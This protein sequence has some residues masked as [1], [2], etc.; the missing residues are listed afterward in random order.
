[1]YVLLPTQNSSSDAYDYAASVRWQEDLW[2]P[3][4]LLY[5]VTG[6]GLY[7]LLQNL[8]FKVAPLPLLQ[9]LNGVLAAGSLVVLWRVLAQ[10]QPSVKVQAGLVL[11]AGAS[12]GTMRYATENETYV[13]P[14]FFSGLGSLYWL[15]YHHKGQASDLVWSSFWAAF[16]CL[17]HQVHFFWWLGLFFS[18]VFFSTHK[19]RLVLV[20]FGLP[21]LVVPLGYAVALL[22]QEI[23]FTQALTFVFKGFYQGQVDTQITYKNFLLTGISFG[24][25]F[26]EVHGRIP[27]LLKHHWVYI[28][29]G[30]T[31]LV[32]GA[33]FLKRIKIGRNWENLRHRPVFKTHGGIMG[34]QL[35][36]AW[37]AVGNA[38]FMVM[39]PWLMAVLLACGTYHR[40]RALFLAG[41]GLLVWNLSFGLV[42]LHLYSFTNF[43]CLS[44]VV[45]QQPKATFFLQDEN[46]FDTFFFYHTGH[47]PA[48]TYETEAAPEVLTQAL[49]VARAQGQPVLTDFNQEPAVLSRK[50]FVARPFAAS[51]FKNYRLTPIASCPTFYGAGP[52]YLVS[53]LTP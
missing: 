36:F 45:L 33:L 20:W 35:L 44:Q 25:T 6:L 27:F 40:S 21:A 46:G 19:K 14:L 17:Y 52:L 41:S 13:L 12:F 4:H 51:F 37:F 50:W 15:R 31:T 28:M 42:P 47:Y 30:M 3:H 11:L 26:L 43:P 9:F 29:F 18:S 34:L 49:A 48:H 5:N 53:D 39:V 7:T 38:E 32:L 2:Q 16:A 23:P 1:M 8:G 10:L 24:R 22:L